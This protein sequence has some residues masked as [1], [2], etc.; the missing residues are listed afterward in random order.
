MAIP[1]FCVHYAIAARAMR[2]AVRPMLLV[3]LFSGISPSNRKYQ[4]A[5]VGKPPIKLGVGPVSVANSRT[6][7][8]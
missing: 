1:V 3:T 4:R 8:G 7:D 5:D 2:A 6:Y